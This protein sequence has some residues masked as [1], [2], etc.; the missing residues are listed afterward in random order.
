MI[1]LD[2]ETSGI[3][4]HKHSILSIGAI[5]MDN[6]GNRFYAECRAWDG[7]H[8]DQEALDING[9]TEEE[10]KDATKKSEEEV[11]RE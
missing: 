2:I 3:D 10:A 5:D 6:P 9:F 4:A 1:A 8:I 7:A 11:V